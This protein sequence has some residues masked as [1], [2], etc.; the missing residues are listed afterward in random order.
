MLILPA[1]AKI[2]WI[3]RV[4]FRRPDGY[5]EI[6]TVLQ[7]ISLRDT[8]SFRLSHD[9]RITLWCDDHSIA[10]DESNLVHR[11]AAELR[12]RFSIKTGAFIRLEKRIPSK[13]GLGGG[14]SDAAISLIAL[15][16]LWQIPVTGAELFELA[17][18]LGA[19]VPFFFIG[20][21]VRATGIGDEIVALPDGPRLFLLIV[22]P[23]AQLSTAQAYQALNAPSLTMPE[24]DTILLSS[25]SSVDADR[26]YSGALRNDFETV[27][28]AL[29]PEIER[30]Q[31]ALITAGANSAL[32]AGSGS[33]V[34]GVF[35][36]REAQERA[37]QAIELEAG[38]RVFPCTTV[39]RDQYIGAMGAC[40][41]MSRGFLEELH[42]GA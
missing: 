9:G 25:A 8:I 33:A 37:I 22:K 28:F 2:N 24:R 1:F 16:H 38:W 5:H 35:D 31:I 7:T 12:R 39:G 42:T 11:A 13:A 20:G 18:K 30:A 15:S 21:S 29:E 41:E 10:V 17:S 4:L 14:S 27:A 36:N 19:D 26:Y 40:G 6:D 32:L 23:K 34:F 3:L